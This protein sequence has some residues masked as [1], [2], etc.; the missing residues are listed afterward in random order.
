MLDIKFIRENKDLV[1][2]AIS[3]K[4]M[5][6]DVE[7]L[8]AVDNTRRDLIRQVEDLNRERNEAAKKRDI[9]TGRKIKTELEKFDNQLREVQKEF[10]KLM[11]Y[12]PNIPSDD[13]PVGPDANSNKE[14]S[15]WGE[16]KDF[17]FEVKDHIELGK[18][19]DIIDLEQG[20]MVSG[21]R[22]YYLKNQGA[23]LHRAILNFAF[24]KIINAG[25]TAMVPPTL[26]HERVLV[27]SGHFPFGKENIYQIANPG[28]VETGEEIKNA[29]FL[30]GT[31]EPSLLAYYMD[32]TLSEDEL[33]IK[34]SAQTQC[35]RSE[36]GDYGKDTR[37]LFRIHEFGKVEQ[38]VIC[39]NN[40]EESEEYFN[41]MQEI[42]EAILKE[43]NIPYHVV[44]TSTGDMGAGKYRM[45]DIEAWMPGRGKYGE[46][47]S[48][49]NLTDWQ[50]RRLNLKFKTKEGK[51]EYC[52]TLNNTVIASPRIL[53]AILEN[54]QRE[55]GSIKIPEVLVPYTDF[56]EILPKNKN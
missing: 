19:L 31:S 26:V 33:P 13:S 42:S 25:F 5:Q 7:K 43:L 35:Y 56:S 44:A 4:G 14:L 8:L 10:D 37:G 27:G 2:K 12:V 9:E 3:E 30:T 40:L 54:Y 15:K 22:G 38:V 20:V 49:S 52:Y 50:S 55:D 11:L 34:I 53:I 47:H 45:N 51:T 21:F 6:F 32:K 48:N 1:Q 18:L 41:E 16:P 17:G 36:V 29:L 24:E 46:T 28:K 39:K 23:L